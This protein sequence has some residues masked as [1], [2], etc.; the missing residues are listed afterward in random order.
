M[1]APRKREIV[2]TAVSITD[3]DEVLDF[4]DAAVD[5]GASTYICCTPASSL[6]FA[7]KDAALS[8]ALNAADVVTPDGMGVV[9]AAR[10]LGEQI[11][12]RVYGPDMMLMQLERAAKD[13]TLTYLYGGHDE[14]ALAELSRSLV[15]RFPG[16]KIIGGESPPHRELTPAEDI[17]TAERIDRSGAEIVW[18]GIGSPKQE[19]WMHRMRDKLD[20]PVLAGVGA[21]FDFHAGRTAQAPD[22]MQNHG[23][24]WVYR[25]LRDPVRLGRRYLAT[26]PHFVLLVARQKLRERR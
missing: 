5:A 12:D 2:G 14:T 6:M 3:Y 10:S 23:L 8:E 11:D 20:A 18:V 24:E 26:L 16:L 1:N 17:A 4:I 22:W 25:I 9:Y 21:A 15:Q 19:L 13:G 7:R